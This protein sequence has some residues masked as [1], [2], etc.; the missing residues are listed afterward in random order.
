MIM[1]HNGGYPLNFGVLI[2]RPF[3]T[4]KEQGFAGDGTTGLTACGAY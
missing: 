1:A 4:S 3:S 2:Q